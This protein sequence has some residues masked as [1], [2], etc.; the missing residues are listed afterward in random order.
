M[1][2]SQAKGSKDAV[3]GLSVLDG[4]A[5]GHWEC[6]FGLRADTGVHAGISSSTPILRTRQMKAAILPQQHLHP[7]TPS[8]PAAVSHQPGS[9][10]LW[11][12]QQ[13]AR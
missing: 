3:T 7:R 6:T 5:S 4:Q 9:P 13:A 2:R 11:H 8:P 10:C 12:W 1:Q